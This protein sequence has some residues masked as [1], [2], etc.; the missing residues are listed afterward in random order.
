MAVF[1]ALCEWGVAR[2]VLNPRKRTGAFTECDLSKISM[3][4]SAG[5]NSYTGQKIEPGDSL[6]VLYYS[7]RVMSRKHNVPLAIRGHCVRNRRSMGGLDKLRIPKGA[8]NLPPGKLLDLFRSGV[9][10]DYHFMFCVGTENGNPVLIQQLGGDEPVEKDE[11][12][13]S[14]NIVVLVGM[15]NMYPTDTPACMFIKKGR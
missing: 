1:C 13:I 8:V 3:M 15:M 7:E 5:M 10:D 6:C 12:K 14:P 11:S 9:F 2:Q 4:F